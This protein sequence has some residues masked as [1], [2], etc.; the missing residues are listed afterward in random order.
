MLQNIRVYKSE[1]DWVFDYPIIAISLKMQKNPLLQPNETAASFLKR[2]KIKPLHNTGIT[3]LDKEITDGL[4]GGDIVELYGR[5][6]SGKTEILLNLIAH[7]VLPEYY[8]GITFGGAGVEVVFFDN[9]CKLNLWRLLSIIEYKVLLAV[10]AKLAPTLKDQELSHE[11][12]CKQFG[13]EAGYE[14]FVRQC[15]GRLKLCRPKTAFQWFVTVLGLVEAATSQNECPR[16]VIV[17]SLNAFYHY[18]KSD[19]ES[20][21]KAL[22]ELAESNVV[23]IATKSPLFYKGGNLQHQEFMCREWTSKVMYRVMLDKEK[24]GT[25]VN[26]VVNCLHK[27]RHGEKTVYKFRV[28]SDCCQFFN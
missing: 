7:C 22:V 5:S 21:A 27:S 9:D 8:N 28:T 15:L 23:I 17:D 25:I 12:V 26:A 1:N 2:N 16:I 11:M 18:N 6:G 19:M 4:C 13:D 14:S 10:Y 24:D 3:F 20:A